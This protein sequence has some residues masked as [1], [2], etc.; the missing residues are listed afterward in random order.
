[1]LHD[2]WQATTKPQWHATV[3]A[4]CSPL[5]GQLGVSQAL[6]LFL[7]GLSRMS[8]GWLAIGWSRLALSGANGVTRLC[9][10]CLSSF[11]R[12]A[13]A[14]PRG[15]DTGGTE[16]EESYSPLNQIGWEQHTVI[17][18]GQTKS[19]DSVQH[20]EWRRHSSSFMEESQSYVVKGVNT[21]KG[22][23]WGQSYTTSCLIQAGVLRASSGGWRGGRQISVE[24]KLHYSIICY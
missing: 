12:L 23:N 13:Q 10:T 24:P 3:S 2:A 7:A 11:S 22:E 18:I 4:Y 21:G 17:S 16:Q 20:Q 19:H 15:S 5:W 14:C 9:S 8:C 6:L 1:M